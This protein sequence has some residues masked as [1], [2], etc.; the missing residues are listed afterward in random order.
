MA[1]AVLRDYRSFTGII[2][3][4]RRAP[5]RA[6]ITT[7]SV[8]ETSLN[9]SPPQDTQLPPR[10]QEQQK[11]QPPKTN[12]PHQY[13]PCIMPSQIFCASNSKPAS[14]CTAGLNERTCSSN[15]ARSPLPAPPPFLP[16]FIT[17]YS[18]G[19]A[20]ASPAPCRARL[21]G[22]AYPGPSSAMGARRR[23]STALSRLG[24]SYQVVHP[25]CAR[26]FRLVQFLPRLA[27]FLWYH[28]CCR[29][30]VSGV[31]K[32]SAGNRRAKFFAMIGSARLVYP[33]SIYNRVSCSRNGLRLP[34]TPTAAHGK[35]VTYSI[36]M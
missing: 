11:P 36:N 26:F 2:T 31:G 8:K 35:C 6:Q 3:D 20:S 25:P 16:T 33:S 9:K 24:S 29:C 15:R 30:S 14:S 17:P 5:Q 12:T 18:T 28:T 13:I 4:S 27:Q 19:V 22:R 1:S 7:T 32:P 10:P 34:C 21:S 23:V